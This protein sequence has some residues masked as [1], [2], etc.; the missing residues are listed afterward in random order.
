MLTA[1]AVLDGY[2]LGVGALHLGVARDERER[3]VVLNAI[4]P[5]WNGNEV[6]LVAAGGMLVVSFP[7]VYASGFS[8]FYLA[9]MLVLWLRI[10]RGV[11]IEFRSQVDNPLWRSL[12]DSG[13]WFGSFLLAILL[14]VAL[15]NVLG[16]LPIGADGFFPGTFA[17]LLNPYSLLTGVLSL[18]IL[19]WHGANYFQTKTEGALLDRARRW[20]GGLWWAAAGLVVVATVATFWV[21]AGVAASFRAYPIACAFPAL[22]ATGLARGFFARSGRGDNAALRSSTLVIVALMGCAACTVY[23]NL[24]TSSINPAYSLTVFN[25]A[26][27]AYALRAA[28]L[29]N[30]LGILGVIIYS[31][32]VH[33]AFRGKVKEDELHY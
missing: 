14:G 5:V 2:D 23:P 19:C 15:G 30:M 10:L 7:R 21:R 25:A 16:G 12:W 9:L 1:Y 8:G 17:L 24:L 18:V 3:R 11:S 4:G 32:Y 6:W 27:S 13:F 31:A 20:S 28:F 26:S 29:A 22:V 33:R